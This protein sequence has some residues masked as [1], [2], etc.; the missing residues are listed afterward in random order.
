[1]SD[2]AFCEIAAGR[3]PATFVREW[4]DTIAILP[5]GDGKRRG[6]TEGHVLVVPK[7][8]V[9]DFRE[10]PAIFAAT[11]LRAAQLAGQLSMDLGEEHWNF[12]TSAGKFATQTVFHLHI[13]LVPR[14]ED[15][16]LLLPWSKPTGV[17]CRKPMA[18]SGR[19]CVEALADGWNTPSDLCSACT[20]AFMTALDGITGPL[21]W[22]Q[23]FQDRVAGA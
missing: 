20:A 10:E 8:H 5:R 1:M 7:T 23:A 16:G 3:G 4:D 12:L 22:H 21:K 19:S 2:C 13:H 6:C 9:R 18:G 17:E 11:A 14:R 15:D